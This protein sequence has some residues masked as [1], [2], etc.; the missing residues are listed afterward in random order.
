MSTN[1][2]KKFILNLFFDHKFEVILLVKFFNL[3]VW[4]L[5][6]VP[7][8]WLIRINKLN[9]DIALGIKITIGWHL[10]RNNNILLYFCIVRM[11]TSWSLNDCTFSCTTTSPFIFVFLKCSTK[12]KLSSSQIPRRFDYK[13]LSQLAH[14]WNWPHVV[15][16]GTILPTPAHPSV[17]PTYDHLSTF[18]FK[19][20]RPDLH[21][22]SVPELYCK[23][24]PSI[25]P[26]VYNQLVSK[27]YISFFSSNP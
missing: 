15:S 27:L 8:F 17:D 21:A 5:S 18:N 7:Y 9:T 2:A 1:S 3:S 24:C 23:R 10:K 6:Q 16:L 11:T 12:L 20:S 19:G 13:E 26:E 14:V 4:V 25:T 22:S